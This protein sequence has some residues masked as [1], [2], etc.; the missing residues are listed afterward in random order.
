MKRIAD[1]PLAG[2]LGELK[3]WYDRTGDQG[4][5]VFEDATGR[6]VDFDLRGT[7]E[8]VLARAM[9]PVTKAGPGRPRLG[10][11]PREVSLLPR[12]WE[13]LEQQP[14]SASAAIRRLVETAMKRDASINRV[15][16]AQEAALRFMT[17]M[18]GD[19]PGFEEACR[20]LYAREESRLNALAR[21]WPPDV[22]AHVERLASPAF[23]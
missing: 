3:A 10:V 15:R 13:W 19:L 8:E 7:L 2:F 18:A 23:R 4:A 11:T 9:P 16:R 1:G 12:H 17:A 22:R 21:K 6:Q 20:A 14:G 5:L